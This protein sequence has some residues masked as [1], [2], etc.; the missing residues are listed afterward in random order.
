VDCT[1]GLQGAFIGIHGRAGDL[2]T[3]D[4]AQQVTG[5]FI[6]VDILIN[7]L[8]VYEAKPFEAISDPD[9]QAIIET[10]FM[11]GV[12]LSRYYLPRP[13]YW[14]TTARGFSF[15]FLRLSCFAS[16][17]R[18]SGTVPALWQLRCPTADNRK[19]VCQAASF[20]D[21]VGHWD[22]EVLR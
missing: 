12:R 10:N 4:A 20:S 11:S 15:A 14:V 17:F 3:A 9:W 18:F 1:L 2:S 13:G 7:N 21:C 16:V 5:R 19:S 22:P 8:G 6:H